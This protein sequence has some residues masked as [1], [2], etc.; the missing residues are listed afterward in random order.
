VWGCLWRRLRFA[1]IVI[2]TCQAQDGKHDDSY[3]EVDHYAHEYGGSHPDCGQKEESGKRG[4]QHC[5]QRID[6]I[7]A[8]G[9]LSEVGQDTGESADQ[10]GQGAAHHEGG[11]KKCQHRDDKTAQVPSHLADMRYV[12]EVDVHCL[13]ERKQPGR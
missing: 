7:E 5:A 8:A 6:A 2:G 13:Q 10:Q 11:H 9:H 12:A 1:F 3:T 4:A